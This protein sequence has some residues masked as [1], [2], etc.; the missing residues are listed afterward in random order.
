MQLVVT[1]MLEAWAVPSA[2]GHWQLPLALPSHLA[3][4]VTVTA[5]SELER[6]SLGSVTYDAVV[7]EDVPPGPPLPERDHIVLIGFGRVGSLV[8]RTLHAAGRPVA[9]LESN[10]DYLEDARVAG[11]AG[12]L[13][14]AA[15]EGTLEAVNIATAR[16]L[17]VA[18]PQTLEAGQIIRRAREA[19][20]AIA[21]M[22]RAHSDEEVAY[23]LRNGADAAIMGEREIARS[24]CESVDGIVRW[25]ESTPPPVTTPVAA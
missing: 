20:P 14:N 5:V 23:L 9:L 19:N 21:V 24:M 18:I 25:F 11:I 16:A 8:G 17:L 15:A 22:A 12:V 7:E 13:G 4:A 1:Y 10:R 2:K 3:H 6:M